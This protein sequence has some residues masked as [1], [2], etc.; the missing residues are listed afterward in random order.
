MNQ[1]EILFLSLTIFLTIVA[2]SISELY[3][4]HKTTPTEQ[5]IESV[6]LEYT[7]DTK[8]ID[9]LEQKIP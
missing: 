8:I 7:I 1:K 3:I 5:E 9:E 4:I 6:K 2:W